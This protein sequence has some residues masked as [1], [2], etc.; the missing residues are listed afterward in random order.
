[1]LTEKIVCSNLFV[2]GVMNF[3]FQDHSLTDLVSNNL[4]SPTVGRNVQTECVSDTHCQ[5]S[6][7]KTEDDK[8]KKSREVQIPRVEWL[9]FTRLQST[10]V[11]WQQRGRDQ[12]EPAPGDDGNVR[13][14]RGLPLFLFLSVPA[15]IPVETTDWDESAS[16]SSAF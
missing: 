5:K 12:N 9:N 8:I 2:K 7:R 11:A 1:M 15:R 13:V 10:F 14:K 6:F 3:V 16:I 4:T